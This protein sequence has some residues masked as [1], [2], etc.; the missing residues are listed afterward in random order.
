MDT[1]SLGALLRAR[2]QG[3]LE[4]PF[5]SR[6][7]AS[8]MYELE[9]RFGMIPDANA[10]AELLPRRG[11]GRLANVSDPLRG[12]LFERLRGIGDPWEDCR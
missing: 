5:I 9:E 10:N 12:R 11:L 4:E 3:R 7:G 6:L 2:L 1:D 8:R